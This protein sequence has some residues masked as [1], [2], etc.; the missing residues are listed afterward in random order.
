MAPDTK[1]KVAHVDRNPYLDARREWNERYGSYIQEARRWRTVA[2]VAAAI[3]LLAVGGV[4]WIGGQSKLVPFLVMINQK[5]EALVGRVATPGE[6]NDDMI[7]ALLAGFVEDWRSVSVDG[8]MQKK[9]I[10]NVYAHLSG[11]DPAFNSINTYYQGNNP[12]ELAGR[13]VVSVDIKSVLRTTKDS[14]QIEWQEQTHDRKG[15]LIKTE[16]WKASVI[17]TLIPPKTEDVIMRNPVGLYVKELTWSQ[18]L[19]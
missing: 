15:N 19:Y 13:Q 16:S 2:A 12:Y 14:L 5:G 1:G 9:M 8:G 3:T 18:Q 10:D 17:V 11:G 7:R 6:V 4:V